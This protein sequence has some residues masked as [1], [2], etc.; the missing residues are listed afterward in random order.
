MATVVLPVA[1]LTP[2]LP[3]TVMVAFAVT[4]RVSNRRYVKYFIYGV[5]VGVGVGVAVAVAVGVGV[6]CMSSGG[7][8]Y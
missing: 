4:A 1:A 2:P 5:G 3:V 8:T 6:G 7:W